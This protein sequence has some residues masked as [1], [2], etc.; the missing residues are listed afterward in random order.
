M[1]GLE[2]RVLSLSFSA[3]SAK[4]IIEETPRKDKKELLQHIEAIERHI[5]AMHRLLMDE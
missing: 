2:M 1:T 4:H 5:E 3:R